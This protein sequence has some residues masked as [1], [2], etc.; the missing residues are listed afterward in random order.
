M[1]LDTDSLAC[2]RWNCIV[3]TSN[4]LLLT[5]DAK[6]DIIYHIQNYE[7]RIIVRFSDIFTIINEKIKPKL[8]MQKINIPHTVVAELKYKG[9]KIYES[10]FFNRKRI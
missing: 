3:Y 10:Y 5:N 2:T 9:R 7:E 1:K 4:K 8:K 6:N